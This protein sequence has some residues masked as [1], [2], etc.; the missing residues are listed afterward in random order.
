MIR[1]SFV[2]MLLCTAVTRASGQPRSVP[3]TRAA[4]AA[5]VATLTARVLSGPVAIDG[6]LTEH[7]W[8]EVPA[9]SNFIQRIPNEGETPTE[10]TEVRVGYDAYALYV[11][12]T[13]FDDE[14]TQISRQ[15]SRRDRQAAADSVTIYLDPRHDHLTGAMFTVSAAG[16]QSDAIIFNDFE[17][18][19]TWDAVW[20]SAV[21]L[22]ERGWVAEVRIPFSQL[23]FSLGDV[24]TWGINVQRFIFRKNEDVWLQLVPR[25]ERGLASRFAHLGGVE[26]IRPHPHLTLL[27]Y[28]ATR[29]EAIAAGPGDPFNDGLRQF[30]SMGLDLKWG[31][32]NTVTL[33]AALNPDFGQVEVDPAVINLTEFEV[34]FEERRGF[35]LEGAQIFS[36]FGRIGSGVATSP[37]DFFYSRRIGRPPQG[38]ADGDY[39]DVP[40]ATTIL[41]AGKLTGKLAN[42]WSFGLLEAVTTSEDARVFVEGMGRSRQQVEPWTNYVVGR[43]LKEGDRSGFGLIATLV[44][45]RLDDPSLRSQLTGRAFTAGYDGY[46][47]FGNRRRRW[48]ASGQAVASHI[49]GSEDVMRRQQSSSRRY[50]QRPDAGYVRLDPASTSLSGW[51]V[52]AAVQRQGGRLR[53]RFTWFATSPGFETNDAGFQQRADEFGF[54]AGLDW[55]N[56]TVGRILRSR[57]VS[58]AKTSRWNFGGQAQRDSWSVSTSLVFPSWWYAD[59]SYAL[60]LSTLDDHLTRGGPLGT[61][62]RSQSLS[63]SLGTDGRHRLWLSGGGSYGWSEAGGWNASGYLSARL[64]P[65]SRVRVT[66]GPYWFRSRSVAQYVTAVTDPTARGTY[67]SRYVFAGLDQVQLSMTSRADISLSPTM[68]IQLYAQPFI[69]VDRYDTYQELAAPRTYDFLRYGIDAGTLTYDADR[70]AYT[71]DPDDTGPAAAFRLFDSDFNSKTLRAKGVFRWEWRPGSTLFVAWTEGRYDGRYP[72]DLSLGRDLRATFAAPADDVFLVKVSYWFGP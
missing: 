11:G 59:G 36:N 46:L 45:R 61:A 16:V 39:V 30:G 29:T 55:Q 57:T 25:V 3:A 58:L 7:A 24:P 51:N 34:N 1:A 40:G 48:V 15:L 70:G 60:N 67:G 18:D 62:P 32:T 42:G 8:A 26:A 17:D 12:V 64:D 68:S 44:D 27:P 54:T 9:W 19:S 20:A 14:P 2:L 21:T 50:Y 37:H 4:S 23:R 6:K 65:S 13:L 49:T 5:E 47:H 22:D 53:P 33:D 63:G 35:F 31:L 71:I 56:Y 43:A 38:G 72:G 52:G 28:T 66:T 41:G 10:R 69:G